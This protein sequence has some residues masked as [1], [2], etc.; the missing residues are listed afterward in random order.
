MHKS[1][2]SSVELMF[3]YRYRRDWVGLSRK[4]VIWAS[5]RVQPFLFRKWISTAHALPIIQ[6]FYFLATVQLLLPPSHSSDESPSQIRSLPLQQERDLI[7]L[8]GW[9][10][11]KVRRSTCRD[12]VLRLDV[13]EKEVAVA[14]YVVGAAELRKW[15]A[16]AH[17]WD[18][19]YW[20]SSGRPLQFAWEIA[21][22]HCRMLKRKMRSHLNAFPWR[23]TYLCF[24]FSSKAVVCDLQHESARCNNQKFDYASSS[25]LPSTEHESPLASQCIFSRDDLSAT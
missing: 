9:A 3:I 11:K 20:M 10:K 18:D 5:W 19:S 7:S 22:T 23:W 8:V 12:L 25:D 16:T 13:L 15:P 2:C 4:N 24:I 1:D 17:L 6:I 14:G 21:T